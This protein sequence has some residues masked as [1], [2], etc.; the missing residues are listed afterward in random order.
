MHSRMRVALVHDWLNQQGGAEVVL[1]QLHRMFPDAPVH[2]SFYDPNLVDPVFRTMEIHPTWLQRLPGWRTRHQAFLPLFPLAFQST[3]VQDVDL[4]VSNASAFCKGIRTPA[5]AVHVCYCLTPTRFIWAPRAYLM[6]EGFPNWLPPVLAPLLWWLRRWDRAAAQRVTQFV[7]I[8]ETV[9][10]RIRHHYGREAP[11]VHPPVDV[12]RFK[13]S[14]EIE[15]HFLVV[16]RLIPYK[17]IDLAVRACTDAELPLLVIGDGRDLHSL[18]EMAGPTVRF[19]GRLSDDEVR[20]H[21][22]RCRAFIFPGEEDFGIAPVE[23]QAAG[24]PVVA[25]AGGGALETV[26]EG[27]TGILFHE[28]NVTSLREALDRVSTMPVNPTELV[29]HAA[30]FDVT[31]F[32]TKLR[33]VIEVTFER[34]RASQVAL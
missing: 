22:A 14:T 16:S 8:S 18:R 7:A 10:K 13:P 3:R 12:T 24:R 26:R 28:Q 1:D 15:N 6:R 32:Q 27:E 20:Q 4:V 9:A 31:E 34:S 29:R 23:A 33:G 5:R 21:M 17:R 19:A 11:V 25:Y 2:T 30:Q